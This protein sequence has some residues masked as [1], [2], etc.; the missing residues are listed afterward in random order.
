MA[1]IADF[2]HEGTNHTTTGCPPAG[3]RRRRATSDS[4][5][6]AWGAAGSPKDGSQGGAPSS[7]TSSACHKRVESTDEEVADVITRMY[8]LYE[9]PNQE[10][11]ALLDAMGVKHFSRFP[12]SLPQHS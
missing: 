7:S 3:A 11:Y 2:K 6:N 12:T 5:E 10:L 9:Q 4:G 1:A 8:Q